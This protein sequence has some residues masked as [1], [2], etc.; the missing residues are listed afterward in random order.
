MDRFVVNFDFFGDLSLDKW[1]NEEDKTEEKKEKYARVTSEELDQL[2]R[3]G[4]EAGTARS[5]SWAVK[6]L[7]DYLTNT[8]QTA[9]FSPV[10]KEELNKILREFYGALISII[11]RM[12]CTDS[13]C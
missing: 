5:T 12:K 11:K 8:G 9:D 2:E 13:T 10:R 3:S 1:L 7:Q 6:C 4:N